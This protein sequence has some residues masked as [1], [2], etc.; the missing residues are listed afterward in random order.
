M[1]FPKIIV[2]DDK[3]LEIGIASEC[4]KDGF[5]SLGRNVIAFDLQHLN[6]AMVS[7]EV[8]ELL[9]A[10]ISYESII[11]NYPDVVFEIFE[12]RE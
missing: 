10:L 11:E 6:F 7:D 2:L 9:R 12:L 1:A 8:S 5:E 3:L 4:F